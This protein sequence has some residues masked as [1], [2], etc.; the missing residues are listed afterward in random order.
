MHC[1]GE[2]N[3]IGKG[4]MTRLNYNVAINEADEMPKPSKTRQNGHSRPFCGH[5]QGL[6]RVYR[7]GTAS[8]RKGPKDYTNS[9]AYKTKSPWNN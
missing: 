2:L 5:A 7:F 3:L 9:N 1:R 6:C 8:D 4:I